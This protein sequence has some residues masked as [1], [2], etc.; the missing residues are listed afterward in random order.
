MT[1]HIPIIAKRVAVILLSIFIV[2]GAAYI[3]Y[4]YITNANASHEANTNQ[5]SSTSATVIAVIKRPNMSEDG[6]FG[7]TVQTSDGQKYSINADPYINTAPSSNSESSVQ[8]NDNCII[9]PYLT[10]NDVVEFSLATPNPDYPS[11]LSVCSTNGTRRYFL[12]IK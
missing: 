10:V 8:T 4:I 12:K 7:Y 2:F 6:F 9:A 3:S 11:D 5:I 1:M